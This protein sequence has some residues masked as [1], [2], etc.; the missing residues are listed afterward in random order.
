LKGPKFESLPLAVL[1]NQGSASAAEIVAG[2][3]KDANRG[4][5]IGETTFGTGTVLQQ[6]RLSDSSAILLAVQEWLTPA[7]YSF[8]HKGI[9]PD[10]AV[11]L[12]DETLILTPEKIKT[13]TATEL[14]ETHDLQL[15][16]AIKVLQAKGGGKEN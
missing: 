12:P 3:I 2:A 7:G 9:Q 6:F 14:A 8:W 16:R 13:M 11:S 10:I 5:L 4:T 1:I 15:L